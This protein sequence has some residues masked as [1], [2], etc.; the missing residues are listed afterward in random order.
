MFLICFVCVVVWLSLYVESL[1]AC[2]SDRLR[3]WLVVRLFVCLFVCFVCSFGLFLSAYD[4]C[5]LVCLSVY[6]ECVCVLYGF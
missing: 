6:G 4:V 5:S 2:L 1:C 3:A